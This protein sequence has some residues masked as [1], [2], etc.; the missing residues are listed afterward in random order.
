MN[1]HARPYFLA[2]AT[3]EPQEERHPWMQNRR[4]AG[5]TAAR[6][7]YLTPVAMWEWLWAR[8]E[9]SGEVISDP[10]T[11]GVGGWCA[12][13][14]WAARQGLRAEL[15]DLEPQ[16]DR[17]LATSS[18]IVRADF[19]LAPPPT[20]KARRTH[21]TNPPFAVQAKWWEKAMRE[22]DEVILVCRA[23]FLATG[24]GRFKEGLHSYWQPA[25][26]WA[27]ELH[28]DEGRRRE[29]HNAHLDAAVA[30]GRI[31]SAQRDREK[32]DV[33]PDSRVRTGYRCSPAGIDHGFAVWRRGY[34]G[35]PAFILEPAGE[36]GQ[37]T[38]FG[39]AP[40][41]RVSTRDELSWRRGA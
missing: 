26:R 20:D 32:L 4:P 16:A 18:P 5:D 29:A 2:P 14:Q 34:R 12:G 23:G 13:G 19:L 36:S 15:A 8:F 21:L 1:T 3:E 28:P 41:R 31:P 30:A 11:A 17:C 35:V 24:R 7:L 27:F 38:L 40:V 25:A 22:A 6:D 9:P 37:P 10:A 33:V 39:G